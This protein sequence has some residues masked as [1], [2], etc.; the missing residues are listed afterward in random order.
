MTLT[1]QFERRKKNLGIAL[2]FLSLVIYKILLIIH[3]LL[4]TLLISGNLASRWATDVPQVVAFFLPLSFGEI[5]GKITVV[6]LNHY[7]VIYD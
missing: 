5:E 2:I 4:L 6:D 3:I 7:L 1:F